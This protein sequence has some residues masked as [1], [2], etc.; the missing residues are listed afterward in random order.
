MSRPSEGFFIGAEGKYPD[1]L[2]IDREAR[3]LRAQHLAALL[4]RAASRVR[5]WLSTRP[6]GD[7]PGGARPS[8]G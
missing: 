5:R 7:L 3:R 6:T 4:R 1:L 8:L 2:A